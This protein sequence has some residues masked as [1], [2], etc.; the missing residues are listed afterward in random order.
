[1]TKM[2]RK[3]TTEISSEAPS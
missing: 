2:K 3:I 1:M